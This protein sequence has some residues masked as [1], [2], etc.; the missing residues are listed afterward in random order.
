MA[1]R[2]LLASLEETQ[3]VGRR[4]AQKTIHPTEIWSRDLLS[5]GNQISGMD[6]I[7]EITEPSSTA[8]KDKNSI[9][10]Q[11]KRSVN[12]QEASLE[13]NGNALSQEE[14]SKGAPS[15]DPY[16]F[17]PS[18][19]DTMDTQE[20]SQNQKNTSD[21]FAFD[22]SAFGSDFGPPIQTG[23]SQ[24]SKTDKKVLTPTSDPYAFDPT[25]FEKEKQPQKPESGN[26]IKNNDPFAF[27][28]SAF[29]SEYQ[30]PVE[31]QPQIESSEKSSEERQRKPSPKKSENQASDPFAFDMSAFGQDFGP[32]PEPQNDETESKSGLNNGQN[33]PF[34]FDMSAFGE[35]HVSQNI[36][37]DRK[38]LERSHT[39]QPF[40]RVNDSNA[41]RKFASKNRFLEFKPSKEPFQP[42]S[43]SDCNKIAAIYHSQPENGSSGDESS[44]E[45]AEPRAN[46]K[47]EVFLEDLANNNDDLLEIKDVATL[48]SEGGPEK[49]S[50]AVSLDF[51]GQNA[52]AHIQVS[53]SVLKLISNK[54][55]LLYVAS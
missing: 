39:N 38:G 6:P 42:L 52:A 23:N 46:L 32:P 50:S 22:M 8:E 31:N 21:P 3:I 37:S 44:D 26:S 13:G 45:D 29:G 48:L 10:G 41:Q 35:D 55:S 36:G 28:M 20:P 15:K 4:N 14:E 25:A 30:P 51:P 24:D 17:D 18:N 19:F 12:N 27:D 33:D 49:I 40:L 11:Q 47:T 2:A 7:P 53:L 54:S 1:I 9:S 5:W 34:A 16:A 43:D